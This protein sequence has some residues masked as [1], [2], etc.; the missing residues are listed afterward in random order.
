MDS[1]I[2]RKFDQMVL[3]DKGEFY[4]KPGREHYALLTWFVS[5]FNN[6]TIVDI[7]THVGSS[8]LALASNDTNKIFTFDI[9]D[10]IHE[11]R[12]RFP[13]NIT[14]F[15][16]NLWKSEVNQKYQ[17]LLMSA[18]MI[19]IDVDPHN[20]NMEREIYALLEKWNYSGL[21]MYDDI[22]LHPCMNQFWDGIPMDKKR[23]LTRFGH[24]SGTGA[25]SY[26]PKVLKKLDHDILKLIGSLEDPPK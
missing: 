16:E 18:K 17:G 21:M 5:K 12:T 15:H 10:K 13:S 26:N 24:W 22:H 23:D 9:E 19:F 2:L 20:G 1:S 8:A 14:F 7:G 25:V 6:Q 11:A 3:G 4:G